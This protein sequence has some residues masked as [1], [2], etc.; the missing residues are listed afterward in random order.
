[1]QQLQQTK[2]THTLTHTHTG[3]LNLF[4]A[5]AR[6]CGP[7][8]GGVLFALC[9]KDLGFYARCRAHRVFWLERIERGW[10]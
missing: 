7:L 4:K 8:Y 9:V 3:A 1:M 10:S 2:H 5:A 6:V